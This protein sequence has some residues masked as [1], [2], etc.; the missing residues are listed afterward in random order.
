MPYLKKKTYK[1][2]LFGG[3]DKKCSSRQ[4]KSIG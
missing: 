3:V 1:M 4:I 2:T